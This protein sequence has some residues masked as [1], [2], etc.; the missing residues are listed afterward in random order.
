MDKPTT[1]RFVM[2]R[3]VAIL[4]ATGAVCLGAQAKAQTAKAD[5]STV[6]YQTKPS[7]GQQC[8]T[9]VQFVAPAACQIVSGTIA[10]T[11]WCQLYSPKS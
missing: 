1:R 4:A 10:P 9:C 7:N 8:S 6:G 2:K 11:A 3:G 5:P